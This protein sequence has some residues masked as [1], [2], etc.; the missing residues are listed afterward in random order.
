MSRHPIFALTVALGKPVTVGRRHQTVTKTPATYD[1][2]MP[3]TDPQSND[4]LPSV[5]IGSSSE[6]VEIADYLQSGLEP[7]CNATLWTQGVFRAS[8]YTLESLIRTAQDADFAVLIAS[9]DDMTH[10]R[11]DTRAVPRDNVIF[12]LG[13]FMGAIGRQRTY[14]V[15][16]HGADLRFP[17]DLDG[18][19]QIRYR[20]RTD[21]NM[22]A[23]VNPAVIQIKESIRELGRKPDH[24]AP[25]LENVTG[26]AAQLM[27]ELDR[28]C[29]SARAQGWRVKTYSDTTL[30][31]ESQRGR[32][33]TF[34]IDEPASTRQELRSFAALLR[35]NGLRVNQ[36][37]LR[38]PRGR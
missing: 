10:F 27:R 34:L 31:L 15:T 28:I 6:G 26:A 20:T 9:P 3:K 22:R 23:M 37:L 36:S 25:G 18:L 33:F 12:E 30:R 4:P 16:E 14:I 21:G 17:S 35:R 11:G 29:V 32:R 1:D 2:H 7:V 13:L 19:T 8:S 38:P 24:T 5:F